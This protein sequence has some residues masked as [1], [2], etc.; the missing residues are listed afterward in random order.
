M[1]TVFVP[2]YDW[3]A[4]YNSV[5]ECAEEAMKYGDMA[6]G[7]EFKLVRLRVYAC[8]T[9]RMVGGKPVPVTMAFPDPKA[10]Q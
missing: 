10:R 1:T 9:Y 7:D 6:E 3:N 8:T 2:D 5:E 4:Q